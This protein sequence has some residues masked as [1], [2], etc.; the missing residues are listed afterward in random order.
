MGRLDY[1]RY[2]DGPLHLTAQEHAGVNQWI[3]D[4]V[5]ALGPTW[6]TGPRED[7]A[8]IPKFVKAMRQRLEAVPYRSQLETLAKRT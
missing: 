3:L 1:L 2:P 6:D 7:Y 5:E 4:L 8:A